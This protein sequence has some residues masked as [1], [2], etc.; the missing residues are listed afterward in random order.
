MTA[1]PNASYVADDQEHL[2]GMI[3]LI[4][5]RR[6][7]GSVVEGLEADPKAG[8]EKAGPAIGATEEVSGEDES[9]ATV[10]A[11]ANVETMAG[12]DSRQA[13]YDALIEQA[14]RTLNRAEQNTLYHIAGYII[15]KV[16]KRPASCRECLSK[17]TIRNP[18][19]LATGPG[20]YTLLRSSTSANPYNH[21]SKQLFDCFLVM[22]LLYRNF[23][24]SI[25]SNFNG[26]LPKM[27]LE[28][29]DVLPTNVLHC[30]K[31]Q[32]QLMDRFIL[33]RLKSGETKKQSQKKV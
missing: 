2:I 33:F 13:R 5:K 7:A 23:R 10:A 11:E 9:A 15:G 32:Q 28:Q 3:D 14:S 21:I 17:C 22:E 12:F 26:N 18:A 4:Q 1:I 27:L 24:G 29:L 8:T 25:P 16:K 31:F 19:E 20:R 6:S 30:R